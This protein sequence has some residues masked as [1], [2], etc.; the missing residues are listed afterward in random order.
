LT[1]PPTGTGND[2]SAEAA[3]V[4][5]ATAAA[6]AWL[7]TAD[8]IEAMLEPLHDLL[9]PA[10]RLRRGETDIDVGCGTGATAAAAAAAV[11]S[12]GRVIAIDAAQN[13]IERARKRA[14]DPDSAVV[15]WVTGDGQRH[16]FAAAAAD[17]I[18]SRLGI[19]FFDDLAAALVNLRAAT[20]P[21]G[22]FTA[23]VWL[24]KDRSP[25]HYRALTVAVD[26]AA[27]LGW[28]VDPG[29]PG[30]GPFGF[31]SDATLAALADAGWRDGRLDPHRVWM[32]AGGPGAAPGVVAHDFFMPQIGSLLA[33]APD[34]IADAVEQAVAR[35]FA[36]CWDG[37]GVRLDAT[38]AIITARA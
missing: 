9:F 8:R 4:A 35:D 17:A 30:A 5:R 6:S 12:P 27:A 21:G 26:T 25:L 15:E 10:A 2:T 20:R 29:P 34:S 19:M 28:P 31:A 11:G 3:V 24:P 38:V 1:V 33:G 7:P 18:V 16:G 32:Y 36:E 22:R 13:A 14:L 37:T 23:V